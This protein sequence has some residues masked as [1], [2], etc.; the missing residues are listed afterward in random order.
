[1]SRSG[2]KKKTKQQVTMIEVTVVGVSNV[3]P[4]KTLSCDRMRYLGFTR[5]DH[6]KIAKFA[7]YGKPPGQA[8]IEQIRK[9]VISVCKTGPRP[10]GRQDFISSSSSW[11]SRPGFEKGW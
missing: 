7:V 6:Y 8:E 2:T 3:G 5:G 11:N 10:S 4:C 1:M 9:R